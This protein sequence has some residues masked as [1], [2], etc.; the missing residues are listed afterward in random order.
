MSFELGWDFIM[1]KK[2]KK[3]K[4]Q[5]GTRGGDIRNSAQ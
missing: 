1:Y 4:R 3:K 2:L 5:V